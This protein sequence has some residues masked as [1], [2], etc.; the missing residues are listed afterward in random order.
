MCVLS[1]PDNYLGIQSERFL[2]TSHE[3]PFNLQNSGPEIAYYITGYLYL[4]KEEM[5]G[6]FSP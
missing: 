2:P 5:E 6:G 3:E 1:M 4:K